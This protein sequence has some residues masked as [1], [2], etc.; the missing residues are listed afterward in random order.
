LQLS[1]YFCVFFRSFQSY[2]QR[3]APSEAIES[4][5][6][7]AAHTAQQQKAD[8]FIAYMMGSAKRPFCLRK[9]KKDCIVQQYH[10]LSE[11]L[12]LAVAAAAT[13]TVGNVQACMH[14]PPE[15]T[16][17]CASPAML[18]GISALPGVQT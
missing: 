14:P 9:D 5:S 11:I 6:K 4:S 1:G 3:P 17:H 12:T 8:S 16:H 2:L 15:T 13:V 18:R 7:T 10:Y